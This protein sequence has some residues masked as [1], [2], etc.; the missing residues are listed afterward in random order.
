MQ[1]YNLYSFLFSMNTTRVPNVHNCNFIRVSIQGR[2]VR[3][4]ISFPVVHTRT[5]KLQ[6]NIHISSLQTLL[7]K[8]LTKMWKICSN[9][10]TR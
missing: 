6:E 8:A 2:N 10:H 5:Q 3:P 7:L 1:S 9:H 4:L